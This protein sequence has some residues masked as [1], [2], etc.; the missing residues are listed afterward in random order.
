MFTLEQ[1]F[2]LSEYLKTAADV[3]FGL[4][5][6]E[7]RKFAYQYAK[8][9]L[10]KIPESWKEN[11]M[12]GPDWFYY[13]MKRH[14]SLS[15]RTPEATSL[16]R[17]TSFNKTNVSRFFA[18]LKSVLEKYKFE[19]QDIYNIDETGITTVQK[20]DRVVA[21]KGFKQIGRITSAERGC[22]VTLAACISAGGTTIPPFFVFPRIKYKDYFVQGAPP[23][24]NGDANKSGWMME[25]NFIKFVK[26]FIHFTRC[27]KERRVLLLLDNHNSHLSIEALDLLK[28]NGVVVLSFPPHCSH[29]L[30]PLDR[31]VFGPL[32]KYVN[33]A[34]DSWMT[35][36][37]GQTM[38]IYHIPSIVNIAFP[39]A[40]TPSNITAGFRVSGI[41]PFNEDIFDD[42]EFLPSSVTDRPPLTPQDEI[43][44]KL[45]PTCLTDAANDPLTQ[46][47]ALAS[48][49][50]QPVT[51]EQVCPLPKAGPR[52]ESNR[53]RKRRKA[54]LLTDTP[55]KNLLAA[56]RCKRTKKPAQN[57]TKR[58]KISKIKNKRSDKKKLEFSSTESES[59][60]IPYAES[61]DSLGPLFD[62]MSEDE[63]SPHNKPSHRTEYEQPQNDDESLQYTGATET[64]LPQND[65]SP[66]E[67]TESKEDSSRNEA[68]RG[69]SSQYHVGDFVLVKYQ[70][71]QYPGMIVDLDTDR[72]DF[73]VTTMMK[74]HKYWRW[75]DVEDRLWYKRSKI[76]R[77]VDP[78]KQIS[79]QPTLFAVDM[80]P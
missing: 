62:T 25:S 23:G 21:R 78:F 61:E 22:L 55:V 24:S 7:V 30:Q 35:N 45:T 44:H 1:E 17:A 67:T 31:S 15:L 70:S 57:E 6:K 18:L 56:E 59:D 5:S 11:E 8:A 4:S 68:G 66:L 2:L 28:E 76:L 79:S 65:D 49:S 33:S 19:P 26:H 42:S 80:K 71:R 52:K 72:D 14:P 36:N 47:A 46:S 53:G 32:K 73:C 34:C 63:S 77:K 60:E 38:T 74:H 16:A 64:E 41:C 39:L 50:N 27:S 9:N 43:T 3:Y 29:K 58:P 48:T 13:F 40:M 37:P 54:E 75:P 10:I 12:A 51:P 69:E 20:P